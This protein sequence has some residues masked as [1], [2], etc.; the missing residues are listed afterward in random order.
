MIWEL[1]LSEKGLKPR[2][3]LYN[4]AIPVII[5]APFTKKNS[6]SRNT[7]RLNI[8]VHVALSQQLCSVIF[9]GGVH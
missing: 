4:K 3:R 9:G 8:Q 1:S 7:A 5:K 6:T 2:I